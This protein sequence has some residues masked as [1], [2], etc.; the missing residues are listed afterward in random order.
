MCTGLHFLCNLN[1]RCLMLELVNDV[2][3][4]VFCVVCH[5]HGFKGW[6]W[7]ELVF[8]FFEIIIVYFCD[9][10]LNFHNL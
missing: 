2:S 6:L 7:T 10:V 3:I 1:A 9:G 5:G 4:A 8:Q